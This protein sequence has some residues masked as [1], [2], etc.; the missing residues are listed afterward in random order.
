LDDWSFEGC[1]FAFFSAGATVSMEFA[2]L[3]A[4]HAAL[5]VDNSSAFRLDPDVPLVV[6]EVNAHRIPARGIV[7]NP[8][9]STIQMVVALEPL[10]RLF[11]LR[12][13]VVSTYQSVSGTR[14]RAGER[15]AVT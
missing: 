8:N 6:P 3:A 5:V 9:C 11:G 15:G 1:D 12:Q 4:R 13:V 2:P 10:H 7:A 14:L